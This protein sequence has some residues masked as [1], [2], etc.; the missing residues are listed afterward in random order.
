M[1]TFLTGEPDKE[2]TPDKQPAT[3]KEAV[4]AALEKRRD[5]AY[6][7]FEKAGEEVD[8]LDE[9]YTASINRFDV[10]T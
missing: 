7:R 6:R 8:R 10:Q 1:E 3:D 5:E 9:E 2:E 4:L